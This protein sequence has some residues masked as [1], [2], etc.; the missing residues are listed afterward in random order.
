MVECGLDRHQNT[1]KGYLSGLFWYHLLKLSSS[2][3]S[4]EEESQFSSPHRDT[5]VSSLFPS[6][7]F[8]TG[9]TFAVG[10]VSACF[11]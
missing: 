2:H 3:E 7:T 8:S 4:A 11:L 5:F 9:V 6:F 10:T 1:G